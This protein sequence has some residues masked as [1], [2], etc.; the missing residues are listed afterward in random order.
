MPLLAP[1]SQLSGPCGSG[2]GNVTADVVVG[3]GDSDVVELT[4]VVVVLLRV[5]AG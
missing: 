5:E 3:L 2:V 4:V 1:A